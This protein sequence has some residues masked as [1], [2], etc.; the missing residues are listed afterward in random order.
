MFDQSLINITHTV[1]T[2]PISNNNKKFINIFYINIR[3]IKNK[4]HE[5]NTYI[6]SHG[7]VYDVIVVAESWIALTDVNMYEMGGYCS[8]HSYRKD[9]VGGGV[10][11]WVHRKYISSLYFE[12]D[13]SYNNF[14]CVYIQQLNIKILGIYNTNNEEFFNVFETFLAEN[15]NCVIVGDFNIDLLQENNIKNYYVNTLTSNGYCILNKIHSEFST[16][17][18]FSSN[19]II[20]HIASDLFNKSFNVSICSHCFSDHE[21]IIVQISVDKQICDKVKYTKTIINYSNFKLEYNADLGNTLNYDQLYKKIDKHIKANTSIRT[22]TSGYKNKLPYITPEIYEQIKKRDLLYRAHKKYINNKIIEKQ[23]KCLR[24]KV[25]LSIR[26]ARRNYEESR[27]SEA[28]T[29]SRKLWKV[30]NSCVFNRNDAAKEKLIKGVC[31]NNVLVT[32]PFL[33]AQN[34]NQ[35]FISS[36]IEQQQNNNLNVISL[37]SRYRGANAFR[38]MNVSDNDVLFTINRLKERTSPGYDNISVRIIKSLVP[39]NLNNFTVIINNIIN[40][41]QFPDEL[42]IA[43]IIPIFKKGQRDLMDNYRPIAILP[44]FAKIIEF[45]MYSQLMNFLR[46]THF[47]HPDQYG[48]LPKSGTEIAA[49]NLIQNINENI[50]RGKLTSAIFIDLKKAFDNINRPIFIRKLCDMNVSNEVIMLI[51]SFLSNRK[52]FVSVD[53]KCSDNVYSECGV[54]QGSRLA[55]LFFLI[56][57]NDIFNCDIFGSIQLYADDIVISYSCDNYCDMKDMMQSDLNKLSRYFNLN[58]LKINDKK[59][60]YM[61]FKNRQRQSDNYNFNILYNDKVIERVN[62]ITYLGLKIDYKLNWHSHI[63]SI[64]NKIYSIIGAIRK[65][66]EVLPRSALIKIYFAH[67]YSHLKFMLPIWSSG[68]KVK[69][70]SIKIIQNKA[71]KIIFNKS[72]LTESALLYNDTF[73]PFEKIIQSDL[74]MLIYKLKN[75]HIR[76]NIPIHMNTD[77]HGYNTRNNFV[78]RNAM[79]TSAA[80]NATISRAITLYNAIPDSLKEITNLIRFK[81]ELRQYINLISVESL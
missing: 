63:D 51:V 39:E 5:L 26:Q 62:E 64:R 50:D 18:T 73:L 24:N 19:T 81:K 9:R 36:T 1:N 41:C 4:L 29:D 15:K 34:F 65:A 11:V 22:I 28:G 60:N 3:S 17:K 42:K 38:F 76:H 67:I 72:R 31:V 79:R 45:I 49:I 58:L 59:T 35:Y 47:F 8:Y 7:I 10:S 70:K 13:D 32:V 78:F 25:L 43:K 52:Q 33:I 14:L 23:F 48:F 30:L 80:H 55:A 61:V 69:L 75:D 21:S 71:L 12:Y 77:L 2:T 53:I 20:D 66:K 44:T 68:P 37:S 16:R 54:P 6:N 56:Y 57:I 27:I 40:D 74:I 46:N